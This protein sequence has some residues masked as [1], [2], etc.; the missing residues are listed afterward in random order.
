MDMAMVN[1][2]VNSIAVRAIARIATR[3]LVRPARSVRIPRRRI[4][5]RFAT[6]IPASIP[7]SGNFLRFCPDYFPLT[8]RPSSMRTI[9]SAICAI[10]SL[11]V[12][13]TM[14]WENFC[15]ATFISPSTS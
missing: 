11:W 6:F 8:I 2:D 3:F 4:H 12:I 13:I 7:E 5:F 1:N 10:S 15:P 9:R 14:V